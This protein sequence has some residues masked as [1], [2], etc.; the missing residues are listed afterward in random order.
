L[1]AAGPLIFV[2]NHPNG[3]LDPL[4]VMAGL[5][6]R[7]A[8][9]AKS[10]FFANP[11]GRA[12]MQAFGALPVYRE[13]DEGKQG[14]ARGD[15]AARNEATFARCRELLRRGEAMALFPEGTTHS[16]S[17]LLPLRSGAARIALSAEDEYEWSL[18]VQIVPV[19]LWYQNKAQF[20]SSALLVVGLPFTLEEFAAPYRDDQRGAVQQLTERVDAALDQVVLQAENAE[21]L[22]GIT[23]VAAWTGPGEDG[24]TLEE[25]R[26]QAALLLAGYERLRQA[27]P[28]RLVALEQQARRYARA[29]RTLGITD[30]WALELAEANRR[31]LAWLLFVLVLGFV[32]A[33]AGFA[34]SYGPYR[35]ARP[36]APYIVGKDDSVTSTGKLIVG[37]ALVLI[38]WIVAALL[39]GWLFGALWGA[40]LFL[41][42]PLLAYI[43]LRWGESWRELREVAAYNWLRLRHGRLADAL[44]AR[45]RAL[46]A[47]V[48][49]AAQLIHSRDAETQS[50][51]ES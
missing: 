41:A 29:L 11:V 21:L 6:R 46:A 25:H 3:L 44:I 27:D 2:L 32:P 1:P 48:M 23:A 33:L 37:S 35:L 36:L 18:G 42:A 34:L 31:R 12:C 8:F 10:T 13:R 15:R 20:R 39:C 17:T 19:G 26:D 47:Q 4:L 5:G 30:P 22:R 16:G 51:P 14:G 24:L 40:L 9:L 45:R 28:Q 49:Q 38:G 50:V 43:A 7:A